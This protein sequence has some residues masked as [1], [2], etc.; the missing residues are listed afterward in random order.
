MREF[1]PGDPGVKTVH[2]VQ[3]VWVRSLAGELTYHKLHGQHRQKQKP[4]EGQ[5][6]T[7]KFKVTSL[8]PRTLHD[9]AFMWQHNRWP[10]PEGAEEK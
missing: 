3:E 8:T 5:Q 10:E 2:S 7:R 6:G 1:Y 4:E 9:G